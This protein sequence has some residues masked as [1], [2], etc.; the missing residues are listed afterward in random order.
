MID[1]RDLFAN[2]TT[3]MIGTSAFGI[4]IDSINNPEN[5]FRKNGRMILDVNNFVRGIQ[6]FV[7]FYYPD[8][9]NFF[10]VTVFGDKCAPF[11]RQV[12]WDAINHRIKSG[13]KRN[14]FIDILIEFKKDYDDEDFKDFR[15]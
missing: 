4:N 6:L 10:H 2:L 15:K 1:A 9:S 14:D 8:L 12:F 5:E 7:G 3:D 11:F 13:E